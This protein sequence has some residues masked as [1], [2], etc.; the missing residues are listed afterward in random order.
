MSGE[1]DRHTD[2]I[3]LGCM[4]E[5]K[6]LRKPMS[7]RDVGSV[8]VDFTAHDGSGAVLKQDRRANETRVNF[9]HRTFRWTLAGFSRVR[10][11]SPADVGWATANAH[12]FREVWR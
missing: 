10:P 1:I 6:E 5:C 8:T 4:F 7:R 12:R 3:A 2:D 11:S 9:G